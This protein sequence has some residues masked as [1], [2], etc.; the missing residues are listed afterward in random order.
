[1]RDARD[2]GIAKQGQ[3]RVIER[4]GGNLDLTARGELLVC[5]NYAAYN[6]DLLTRHAGLILERVTAFLSKQALNV[7]VVGLKLFIE[8]GKLREHLQIADVLCAKHSPGTL[9]IAPGS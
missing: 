1:M 8:P 9:R 7:L 6:L 5:R 3:D 2:V 4:R